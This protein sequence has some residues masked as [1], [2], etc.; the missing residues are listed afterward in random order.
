MMDWNRLQKAL[1]IEAE[2]GFNDLQGNYYRFSE[3]LSL[4]LNQPAGDFSFD[5]QRRLQDFGSQFTTY[6]ELTFHERQHLVSE[7]RRYLQQMQRVYEPKSKSAE[8]PS[9]SPAPPP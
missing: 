8:S 7:T 9:P 4:T 6:S 3:F 5:Q 2:Q 1:S